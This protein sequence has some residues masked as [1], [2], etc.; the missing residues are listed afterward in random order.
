MS[1]FAAMRR[2]ILERRWPVIAAP[3]LWLGL[4]FAV[5]FVI[6]LKIALAEAVIG[7]PPFTP[8]LL[9]GEEGLRAVQAT[10]RNFALLFE[11]DLYLYAYLNSLRIAALA[12]LGALIIGFPIAY[13]IARAPETWR[14]LL[15][16]LAILPFWTSFLVR[17]YAWMGLLRDNGI[18]NNMLLSAGLIDAPLRMMN[19]EFAVLVGIVYTYLPFMVLPL[20]AALERQ[21]RALTEAAADLGARPIRGFIAIT[22]P[23]SLPGIV[24]GSLLVFIPA[25]GEYVI[26]ELLGGADTL[27]IGRVIWQ[28]FFNNRDWPLAAAIAVVLLILL[29]APLMWLQRLEGRETEAIGKAVAETAEEARK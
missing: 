2:A 5:P 1:R 22:L 21:D 17:V 18:I 24:A 16:L 10:W 12:T 23:L 25:V 14:P 26:P 9:W 29:V 11:D 19:T 28:E 15:L 7:Q 27:M 8:L 3:Y 13:A 6:V 4:F 20:Y